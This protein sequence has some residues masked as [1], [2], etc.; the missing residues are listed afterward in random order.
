M[1][2]DHRTLQVWQKA[3]QVTRWVVHISQRNFRA[4]VRVPF[5]HL[6][7]AVL[8]VQLSVARGHALKSTRIFKRHLKL[9]YAH[10]IEAHELLQLMESTHLVPS[11]EVVDT[12]TA[13]DEV[14]GLLLALIREYRHY[15]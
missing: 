9:A 10:A 12:L 8:G 7:A 15:R 6:Q 5:Y 4:P 14:K 2:A 11:A 13:M 1:A 3:N